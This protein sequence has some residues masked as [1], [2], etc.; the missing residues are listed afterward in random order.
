[1]SIIQKATNAAT[2]KLWAQCKMPAQEIV[3]IIV[4]EFEAALKTYF[5]G[6]IG[7]NMTY[8]DQILCNV[9]RDLTGYDPRKD[10]DSALLGRKFEDKEK[11]DE[12]D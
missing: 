10:T 11:P 3:E 12:R 5:D 8:T 6:I 9:C 1:M 7:K 2:E 4:T